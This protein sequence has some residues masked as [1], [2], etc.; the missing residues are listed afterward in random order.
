MEDFDLFRLDGHSLRVFVS[1]CETGSVSRTAEAFDLNQSTISHTVDKLRAAVGDP[2]F[3][4]SGRGI[5]PTEKALLILPRVQRILADIE[6]LVAPESYDAG[7]ETKP[8]VI[9]IPTP[10]ILEDMKALQARIAVAAPKAGFVLKRLAPRERVTEIL[11]LDEADAV[12]AVSGF[13]YPP[14]LKAQTYGSDQL[15]VFFDPTRRGP[16]RT[17]EDYA[18]ARH[19]TVNFGG[20]VKSEVEKTL[21]EM[22]LKRHIALVA[23]TAS[24][25]GGL[26]RGTD[27]IAT[28]PSRLA[29]YTY[30]GLAQTA[31]PIALP[32]IEYELVWHRR[33]DHSG[34]NAWFRNQIQETGSIQQRAA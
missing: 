33:Y 22:G 23:P 24:M 9:A 15:A 31:P 14:T 10:A 7:S 5:T 29:E 21:R 20:G 4:K 1:V 27:I 30:H 19:G 32:P 25:L 2:L 13:R 16:V 6:G 18:S 3:V 12:I 34:R 17:I 8:F 26:I 28:M 11:S